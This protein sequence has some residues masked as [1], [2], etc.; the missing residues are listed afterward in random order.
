MNKN[1]LSKKL[2]ERS[3]ISY[4]VAKVGVRYYYLDSKGNQ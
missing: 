1:D 3:N 4:N 2:S